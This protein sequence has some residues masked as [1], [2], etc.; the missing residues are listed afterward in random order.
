LLRLEITERPTTIMM[1]RWENHY[2]ATEAF[3]RVPLDFSSFVSKAKY[4]KHNAENHETH[5]KPLIRI[6]VDMN[7]ICVSKVP[8][9][10]VNFGKGMQETTPF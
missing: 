6:G 9:S 7:N 3:W 8:L 4:H 5:S 10:L 1:K 2:S